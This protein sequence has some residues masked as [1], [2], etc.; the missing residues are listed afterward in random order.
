ML[1]YSK[2]LFDLFETWTFRKTKNYWFSFSNKKY[3]AHWSLGTFQNSTFPSIFIQENITVKKR[4][5][6][7]LRAPSNFNELDISYYWTKINNFWFFGKFGFQRTQKTTCCSITLKTVRK[8]PP[9]YIHVTLLKQYYLINFH[10]W[11]YGPLRVRSFKG[12]FSHKHQ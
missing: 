5:V 2:L 4:N 1:Y 12:P 9:T 7:F 11:E 3:P 6:L 10:I 8:T